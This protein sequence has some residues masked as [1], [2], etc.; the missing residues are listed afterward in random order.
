MTRLTNPQTLHTLIDTLAAQ[1][2]H[3]Q[4]LFQQ[5]SYPP[6]WQREQT[7]A[8]LI[9]V[10]LEQQVSLAS[11]KAAF[12]RLCAELNDNVTPESFLYLTDSQLRAAGFSRQKTKYGR[13]LADALLR[14]DVVLADLPALSDEEVRAQLVAVKGI[15]NWTAD[16]YLMMCLG[17]VNLWPVGDRALAVAVKEVL[18]LPAVPKK[19][20]LE[21]IGDQYRPYRTAAAFLF[22]HYYL[23][24]R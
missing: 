19:D 2:P 10:I 12:D 14:G 6:F 13:C 3:L 11:A 15:G 7:F 4:Q 9:H 21:K 17:R 5:Y 23:H 1:H 18:Q 22:W 16:V 8:T 20:E 24:T